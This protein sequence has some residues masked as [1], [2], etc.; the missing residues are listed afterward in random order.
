[1]DGTLVTP[2]RSTRTCVSVRDPS[3]SKRLGSSKGL[4]S[5]LSLA[6]AITGGGSKWDDAKAA[7]GS[8]QVELKRDV[9]VTSQF[10]LSPAL[11]CQ[12]TR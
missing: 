10:S 5:K 7:Q 2:H 4:H 3:P 9:I 1:M 8:S 11:I 6:P 12:A